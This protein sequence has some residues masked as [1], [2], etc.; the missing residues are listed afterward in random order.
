MSKNTSIESLINTLLCMYSSPE[1]LI[2]DLNPNLE[3]LVESLLVNYYDE[4]VQLV[5]D[6]YS[7]EVD[8]DDY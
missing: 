3:E 4:L 7:S 5:M 1:E 8:C 6:R 2:N